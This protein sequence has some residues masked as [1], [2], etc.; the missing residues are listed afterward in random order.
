M[1][2]ASTVKSALTVATS[3][4]QSIAIMITEEGKR[5]IEE[6][7]CELNV[8]TAVNFQLLRLID[9]TISQC[10]NPACEKTIPF[11][12]HYDNLLTF[13]CCQECAEKAILFAA[14]SQITHI[15][16][17]ICFLET[18]VRES[19]RDNSLT[20]V[21]KGDL[22]DRANMQI[23]D[24]SSEI[25]RNKRGRLQNLQHVV[26]ALTNNVLSME[27][28]TKSCEEEIPLPA[29][30]QSPEIRFCPSCQ[31]KKKMR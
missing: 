8:V 28:A 25:L 22:A 17:E 15:R 24:I 31:E 3:D 20:A 30:L 7:D 6:G 13:T 23:G 26:T 27:C 14:N 16:E 5:L 21:K 19:I 11:L 18:R 29:Q 12:A 4:K 10:L 1:K 2:T 9:G